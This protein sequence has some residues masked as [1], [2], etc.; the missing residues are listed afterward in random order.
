[1]L[2]QHDELHWPSVAF[3]DRILEQRTPSEPL[4]SDGG[5]DADGEGSSASG[6]DQAAEVRCAVRSGSELCFSVERAAFKMDRAGARERG[7]ELALARRQR[8]Q[9]KKPRRSAGRKTDRD[10]WQRRRSGRGPVAPGGW[11]TTEVDCTSVRPSTLLYILSLQAPREEAESSDEESVVLSSSTAAGGWAADIDESHVPMLVCDDNE[12]ARAIQSGAVALR[13]DFTDSLPQVTQAYL[14]SIAATVGADPPRLKRLDFSSG[15]LNAD[16]VPALLDIVGQCKKLERLDLGAN[17]LAHKTRGEPTRLA[18]LMIT[19]PNLKHVNASGRMHVCGWTQDRWGG[20]YRAWECLP[21]ID[22]AWV[23]AL[24]G[25]RCSVLHHLDLSCNNLRGSFYSVFVN[26]L[27]SSCALQHLDLSGN[28]LGPV[29]AR[30]LA[31]KLKDNSTLRYLNISGRI[32]VE[33]QCED[34][35]ISTCWQPNVGEGLCAILHALTENT[36]LR[37]LEAAYNLVAPGDHRRNMCIFSQAAELIRLNST[38]ERLN[39][40]GVGLFAVGTT[41]VIETENALFL[42]ARSLA[43][44]HSVRYLDLCAAGSEF[45]DLGSAGPALLAAFEANERLIELRLQGVCTQDVVWAAERLSEMRD[46]SMMLLTLHFGPCGHADWVTVLCTAMDGEE[47]AS[48]RASIVQPISALRDSVFQVLGESQPF[49][50]M[51]W[52]GRVLRAAEDGQLLADVLSS[53]AFAADDRE[54]A[55]I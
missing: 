49:Q 2:E 13:C 17:R 15:D 34:G 11:A 29:F 28:I 7:R 47:M 32:T 33:R 31:Q 27:D 4:A 3:G 14:A 22:A 20:W 6:C 50:I 30:A 55:L 38:L 36:C 52:D 46:P 54:A 37:H 1:M 35:Q 48:V 41:R 26:L 42:L 21:N 43:Q 45:L 53:D 24:L 18:T 23:K 9:P 12:A 16:N 39:L 10:A 19:C 8:E 25:P 5:D 51:L 44:N 40:A